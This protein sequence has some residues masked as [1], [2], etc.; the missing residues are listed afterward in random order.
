MRSSRDWLMPVVELLHKK[1][2]EET[3][4][5]ADETPVTV[6]KEPNRKNTAVSYMWVYASGKYGAKHAIRIFEYQPV[7]IYSYSEYTST[8]TIFIYTVLLYGSF[9]L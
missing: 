1:L 6:M 8:T 2:L 3:Y 7:D 5:H 9:Q 4:I